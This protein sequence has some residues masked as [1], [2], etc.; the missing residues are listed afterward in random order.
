MKGFRKT[1]GLATRKR[2]TGGILEL[3]QVLLNTICNLVALFLEALMV[4]QTL[5]MKGFQLL[6]GP[7]R[8]VL[9]RQQ[10]LKLWLCR[11]DHILYK[12]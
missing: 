10:I 11:S 1:S 6:A 12:V 5:A 9:E 8:L 2:Q 3:L 7:R 4:L